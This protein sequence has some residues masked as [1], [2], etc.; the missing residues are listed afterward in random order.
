MT[1]P[2]LAG[3]MPFRAARHE[4]RMVVDWFRPGALRPVDP[5]FHDTLA[6]AF[7]SPFNLA[8]WRRTPIE[9]LAALPRGLAPSGFVFH[10]SRC[11]STLCAQ[12]LA[13]DPSN[14]VLSEPGP[15]SA[16]PAFPSAYQRLDPVYWGDQESQIVSWFEQ[17]IK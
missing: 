5:F 14:I 3:W 17:N 4:G 2:S 16:V 11:G 8:L 7:R 15:V 6:R 1:A 9:A 13:R 12:A 10:M